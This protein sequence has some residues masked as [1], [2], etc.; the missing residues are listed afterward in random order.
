MDQPGRGPQAPG[1]QA[2]STPPSKGSLR[3][4]GTPLI[5]QQTAP[6]QRRT[7]VDTQLHTY[8]SRHCSLPP[9]PATLVFIR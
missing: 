4:R 1:V 7:H 5:V 6:W 8:G 9:A 3:D 2:P